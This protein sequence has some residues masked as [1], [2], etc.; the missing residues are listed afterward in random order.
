M[1]EDLASLN[2]IAM[3]T[4]RWKKTTIRVRKK[5]GLEMMVSE[6][7]RLALMGIAREI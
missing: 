4:L 3:A 5:K 2:S 1:R 6:T 7:I